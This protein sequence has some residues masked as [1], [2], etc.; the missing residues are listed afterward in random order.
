M[1]SILCLWTLLY[2]AMRLQLKPRHSLSCA[3]TQAPGSGLLFLL[4]A[5]SGAPSP[6]LWP[7]PWTP[8]PQNKAGPEGRREVWAQILEGR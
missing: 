4:A 7:W 3:R 5:R 6:S 1:T 2:L 8:Q